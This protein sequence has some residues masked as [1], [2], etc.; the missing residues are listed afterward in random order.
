MGENR[1]RP[2][3]FLHIGLQKTGTTSLQ[4]FLFD[5]QSLLQRQGYYYPTALGRVNHIYLAV[6]NQGLNKIDDIRRSLGIKSPTDV[7]RAKEETL[8]KIQ[9][10]LEDLQSPPKHIIMSNEHVHGR[11]V[12]KAEVLSLREFVSSFCET[13]KV[14]IY[15]RRQ[16]QLAVSLYSTRFRAGATELA[17]VFPVNQ[18]DFYD[19]DRRLSQFSNV[20]ERENIIVRLFDKSELK[21]EDL[22]TDFCDVVGITNNS[23]FRRPGVLNQPLKP[24]A[25]RLFAELNKHIPRF[26]NG[27]PNRDF[28]LILNAFDSL[29]CGH[30]P[31][32]DRATAMQFYERFKEGNERVRSTY[33]SARQQPLFDETFDDYPETMPSMDYSYEDA[34]KLSSELLRFLIQKIERH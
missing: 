16:D 5:N 2:T 20:F 31:I 34:V 14:V 25:I 9:K 30:G 29:F 13:C 4:Q 32:T 33:F 11:I 10:E 23:A 7:V 15:L 12:T 24:E 27:R 19:Y 3:G 22:F 6:C 18:L 17:P 21:D 8:Q 1:T 28:S 26:L